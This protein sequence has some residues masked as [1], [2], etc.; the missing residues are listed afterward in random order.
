[1]AQSII[2]KKGLKELK[3]LYLKNEDSKDYIY[4]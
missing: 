2:V 1:M 3:D 4:R